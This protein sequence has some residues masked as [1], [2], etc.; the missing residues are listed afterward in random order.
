MNN[1]KILDC[2]LRDGG[3]V[4]DMNFGPR[5]IRGIIGKL[6]EAS[7]DVIECGFLKDIEYDRKLT[8]FKHVEQIREFLPVKKNP[9]TSF[10]ALLDFGRYSLENLSDYDGTSIDG[11]RICFVK[12]DNFDEVFKYAKAIKNKGYKIYLQPTA[13][14]GYTDK[15]ILSLLDRANILD[16]YA[17]SI[18]DTFGS[19]YKEDLSHLFNIVHR[20]LNSNIRIGFHSHNNLQL[21]FALCQEFVHMAQG[22]R[23]ITIDTSVCGLGRG[24][25]NA[26]TE[27]VANFLNDRYYYNYD[28]NLILDIVDIYMPK[29]EREGQWGYSIPYFIA[30]IHNSHVNNINHLL[31]KHNITTKD[32]QQII[33]CIDKVARKKYNYDELN[34][35]YLSYFDKRVDDTGNLEYIRSAVENKKVLILAP[36]KNLELKKENIESYIKKNDPVIIMVHMT[37]KDYNPDFVFYSSKR[38]YETNADEEDLRFSDL[39]KIVTSN[40]HIDPG[41]NEYIINFERLIK[42]N[43]RYFDNSM[44][45]LLRL[46][47][48]TNPMEVAIAGFDGFT[49]G[50]DNFIENRDKTEPYIDPNERKKMNEEIKEMLTDIKKSYNGIRTRFLTDSLYA[51]VFESPEGD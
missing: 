30:G 38:R 24:A 18:V 17:F 7:I 6:D 9:E 23:E 36:G 32:L 34:N 27:L 40:I 21:S 20:N 25:G 51:P 43:W 22:R 8:L 39:P 45:L 31:D 16:P 42:P 5:A 29:I 12:E 19:M 3:F 37:N 35:L 11:I 13:I 48:K 41:S 14:M 26:N 49:N 1:I 33:L 2:T 50:Q 15:E 46:I 28:L 4:V 10:V 44:V 47:S